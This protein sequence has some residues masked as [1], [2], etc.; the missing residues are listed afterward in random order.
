MAAHKGNVISTSNFDAG[1]IPSE[2]FDDIQTRNNVVSLTELLAQTAPHSYNEIVLRASGDYPPLHIVGV[3]VKTQFNG[4][5]Y[6]VLTTNQVKY[7]AEK[8]AIPVVE[9]RTPRVEDSDLTMVP[10]RYTT[11][12]K[13]LKMGRN[14]IE[15]SCKLD[16]QLPAFL[17]N[18]D[19]DG[20]RFM[21]AKERD[22][23]IRE[24]QKSNYSQDPEVQNLLRFLESD[25]VSRLVTEPNSIP[26]SLSPI[27][28]QAH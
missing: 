20:A 5:P 26:N 25:Q 19:G 8:L 4:I 6:D 7:L 13:I 14:G 15:Y 18:Y 9:F 3:Y 2:K 17:V 1:T 22:E 16:P 27:G 23:F 24:L 12:I 21:T 11:S 28:Y 10:D